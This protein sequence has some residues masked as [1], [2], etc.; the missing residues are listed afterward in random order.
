MENQAAKE[1]VKSAKPES[2][3]GSEKPNKRRGM[4]SSADRIP[5]KAKSSDKFCQLCKE[6][7]GPH[8]THNTSDCRKYE[9]DGTK[10]K[11]GKS[12]KFQKSDGNSYA[13]MQVKLENSRNL[14]RRPQRSILARK[15]IAT[16]VTPTTNRKVCQSVGIREMES[17]KLRE[18]AMR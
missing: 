9:K 7:G 4:S 5:K 1:K 10:K 14:S 3:T 2:K 15:S 6:Y 16:T 13:N 17:S 8:K 18:E 12:G 11:F